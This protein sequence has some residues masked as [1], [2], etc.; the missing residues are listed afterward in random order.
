MDELHVNKQAEEYYNVTR[1]KALPVDYKYLAERQRKSHDRKA[2][3]VT[4]VFVVIVLAALTWGV[5]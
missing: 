3:V 5:L 2:L 1:F 4:A